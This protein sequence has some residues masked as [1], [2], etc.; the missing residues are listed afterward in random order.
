MAALGDERLM[1]LHAQKCNS[2][3]DINF[4]PERLSVTLNECPWQSVV[5]PHKKETLVEFYDRV[6]KECLDLPDAKADMDRACVD[7][8]RNI[9]NLEGSQVPHDLAFRDRFNIDKEAFEEARPDARSP[10]H[11]RLAG[12][13][14][15]PTGASHFLVIEYQAKSGRPR[16]PVTH[17]GSRNIPTWGIDHPCFWSE[18]KENIIEYMVVA[19][20]CSM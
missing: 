5:V 19:V 2:M 6:E 7:V 20:L 16:G 14:H 18:Y 3:R 11:S 8:H 17:W 13:V 12:A 15:G 10:C 1:G 4:G 9:D